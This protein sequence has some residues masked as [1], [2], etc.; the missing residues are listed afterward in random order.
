MN[1]PNLNL[2]S[3][4]VSPEERSGDEYVKTM[5]CEKTAE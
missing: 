2:T 3:K 5:H 4:P 1:D